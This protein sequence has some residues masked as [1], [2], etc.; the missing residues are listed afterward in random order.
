M[1]RQCESKKKSFRNYGEA[2]NYVAKVK[3]R[4]PSF[5]VRNVYQCG[6]CRSWHLT[7]SPRHGGAKATE[8]VSMDAILHYAHELRSRTVEDPSC[9]RAPVSTG[10]KL[11]RMA[12]AAPLS[13]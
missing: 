8:P 3:R 12:R 2:T 7:S 4:D 9:L 1:A 10:A 6:S 11:N 13:R 5:R